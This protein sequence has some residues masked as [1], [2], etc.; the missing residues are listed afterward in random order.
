M[1]YKQQKIAAY[2]PLKNNFDNFLRL[3]N[4]ADTPFRFNDVVRR[5]WQKIWK[6]RI[7]PGYVLTE[8]VSISMCCEQQKTLANNPFERPV[9][10]FFYA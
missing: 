6:S 4:I 8:F 1:C 5:T 9:L 3:N 10:T 7:S 2:N